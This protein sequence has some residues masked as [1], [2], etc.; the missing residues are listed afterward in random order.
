MSK[1]LVTGGC[2]FIGGHI[3]DKLVNLGHE[4]VVVDDY[5]AECNDNFHHNR[6]ARYNN[7]DITNYHKLLPCFQDVEYV[8]HLAALARIMVCMETP[9]KAC[10]VNFMGTCNVLEASRISQVKRV[11]YSSTSSAY[12]L[13]NDPPLK[14]S[15]PRDCLNPYSATKVAAEDLVRMYYTLWGLESVTFRYFNVYGER[16]PTKGQYAP[17]IGL[18]KKQK[19]AGQA[20][21]VVGDG[22]QRRDYTHVSD[23]AEANLRAAFTDNKKA[24][25]E[26]INI[27]TGTNH[28]VLDL[29][30]L[31][32]GD[33]EHIP[34]RPGEARE[35]LAD[36]TKLKELLD[37]TPQVQLENWIKENE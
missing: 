14:E 21:T 24:L 20:M 16:Q 35:T 32:G 23:V 10:S 27:G 37:Y 2:G 6:K 25:G 1:C 18:F 4:V 7:V 26:V 34:D 19:E 13:R 9:Q 17:V 15:M 33:Y 30:N 31:I 28:S 11:V 36:I 29:I 12:G 3:V 8:F 5:S 22:E